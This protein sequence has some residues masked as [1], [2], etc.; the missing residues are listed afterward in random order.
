MPVY[1]VAAAAVVDS[2]R[3]LTPSRQRAT[4][5]AIAATGEVVA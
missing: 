1:V 5:I 2:D 3:A 4:T